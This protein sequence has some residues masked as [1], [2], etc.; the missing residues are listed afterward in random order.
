MA[1]MTSHRGFSSGYKRWI[2]VLILKHERFRW[3]LL[4]TAKIALHTLSNEA[5]FLTNDAHRDGFFTTINK[6]PAT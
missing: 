2:F 1:S 5:V 6:T 3:T 4:I